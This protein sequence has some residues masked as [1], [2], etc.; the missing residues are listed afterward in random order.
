MNTS[1]SRSVQQAQAKNRPIRFSFLFQHSLSVTYLA[2]SSALHHAS[3]R[4]ASPPPPHAFP[5]PRQPS[6]PT[7]HA[8]PTPRQ[9]SPPT[10]HVFSAPRQASPPPSWSP[11]A[12]KNPLPSPFGPLECKNHLH[13]PSVETQKPMVKLHRPL[14]SSQKIFLSIP[15]K[16]FDSSLPAPRRTRVAPRNIPSWLHSKR[17]TPLY[18]TLLPTRFFLNGKFNSYPQSRTLPRSAA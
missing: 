3:T 8:F 17:C 15:Q 9:A 14:P 12:Y 1:L 5:A 2:R 7:P 6:P 16:F 13:R 10:P 11:T 4:Q 18:S